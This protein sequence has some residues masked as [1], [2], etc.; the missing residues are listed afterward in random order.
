MSCKLMPMESTQ[1]A[2]FEIAALLIVI[3]LSYVLAYLVK[4]FTANTYED[5][6]LKLFSLYWNGEPEDEIYAWMK[7]R[8]ILKERE[9]S[10]KKI[11]YVNQKINDMNKQALYGSWQ[12]SGKGE[13]LTDRH[14]KE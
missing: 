7:V 8:S 6:I 13:L 5:E 2:L 12:V 4:R 10:Q 9:G 14:F 11:R 1:F 3:P